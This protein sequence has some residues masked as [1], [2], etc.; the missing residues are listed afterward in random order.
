MLT[1]PG[2]GIAQEKD[3]IALDTVDFAPRIHDPGVVRRDDGDDI[4]ALR[5]QFGQLLDEGREMHCLAA[6]GEGA[7]HADDDYFLARPVFGG[8]IFLGLV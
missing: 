2:L 3:I 5:L 7:G 4:H 1:K 6:W 8:V